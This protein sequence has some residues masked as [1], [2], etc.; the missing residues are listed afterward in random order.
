MNCNSSNQILKFPDR[1][2]L[3]TLLLTLFTILCSQ[4]FAESRRPNIILI[5]SDDQGWGQ[6]GYMNHPHLKGNTPNLDEMAGAGIRFNRFYAAASVCSPT[7][8]SVLTGRS[9]RRTGVPALHKRFGLKGCNRG[10]V[11]V[12]H[13]KLPEGGRHP[14]G[15]NTDLSHRRKL[16]SYEVETAFYKNRSSRCNDFCRVPKCLAVAADESETLMVLEDLDASGFPVRKSYVDWSEISVC[17]SWLANFHAVY[18]GEKPDNLWETGTYWH[19]ETRP[20]EL[21]VLD[22][23]SLKKAAGAI[24]EKLKK[25]RFQTFV[26][27]DAKLANFCFSEDGT[28]V[29]AVDFQYVGGGCGMKDLAYFVGSCLD[30]RDCESMEEEILVIYFNELKTALNRVD[31]DVDFKLL[32]TDWR[33][34]YPVAWT[35]FHRF[36]KGW[37]PGHW[38]INTYS[39]RVTRKVV[40]DL[41]F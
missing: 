29:A 36:L 4:V 24:D 26:H 19:L 16:K 25:S 13:V 28:K 38:K 27:G 21:T 6:V 40:K 37:S 8:A 32:E 15:W 41:G 5:M 12:K 2:Y 3:C 22:D 34:L 39:E 20:D 1:R 31:K 18:L 10:S 30:E 33:S 9:P 17:L 23:I 14:R 7:R 11:V 35:D